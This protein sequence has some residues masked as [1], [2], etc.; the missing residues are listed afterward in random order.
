MKPSDQIDQ[1]I[2][3]IKSL[4]I[5]STT[6]NIQNITEITNKKHDHNTNI[7]HFDT[8]IQQPKFVVSTIMCVKGDESEDSSLK[9]HSE[10]D[11]EAFNDLDTSNPDINSFPYRPCR[12][13]IKHSKKKRKRT[14]KE[15]TV[16]KFKQMQVER[17]K[18]SRD[19]VDSTTIQPFLDNLH[20]TG[21]DHNHATTAAIEDTVYV[22]M[23]L[24]RPL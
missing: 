8:S 10:S 21:F 15:K 7:A 13:D 23:L 3:C 20:R 16:G 9:E 18:G 6:S 22:S 11:K 24:N 1:L 5:T 17:Y 12:I 2:C 14:K 4:S 19:D